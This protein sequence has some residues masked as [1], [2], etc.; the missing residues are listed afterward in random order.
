MDHVID[1]IHKPLSIDYDIK[2]NQIDL[3]SVQLNSIQ[4]RICYVMKFLVLRAVARECRDRVDSFKCT[5]FAKQNIW[6]RA[7]YAFKIWSS[8]KHPEI[9]YR[10]NVEFPVSFNRSFCVNL[11]SKMCGTWWNI[12][13]NYMYVDFYE[14]TCPSIRK[15]FAKILYPFLKVDLTQEAL[16]AS[17]DVYLNNTIQKQSLM[18]KFN[19]FSFSNKKQILL[20]FDIQNK[21]GV[22]LTSLCFPKAHLEYRGFT[23]RD[24]VRT[25]CIIL[26]FQF[27][28]HGCLLI[29]TGVISP[30]FKQRH[31]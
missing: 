20:D 3:P 10:N 9:A 7:L 19:R 2:E 16:N 1:W 30:F 4:E 25:S 6:W 11:T 28:F 31:F 24:G 23:V 13:I 8:K 29:A 5:L 22:S 21:A 17:V 26:D 14:C 18:I 27:E 15:E 12:L